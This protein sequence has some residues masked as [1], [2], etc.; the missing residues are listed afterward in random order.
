MFS[1]PFSTAALIGAFA[2]GALCRWP[3]AEDLRRAVLVPAEPVQQT[4][5]E[6]PREAVE[7]AAESASPPP[8]CVCECICG[9][10]GVAPEAT[11]CTIGL[12]LWASAEVRLTLAGLATAAVSFLIGCC[13][14]RPVP[15]ERRPSAL[16]RLEGYRS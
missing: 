1:G 16:S 7:T 13:C 11:P 6:E 9:L 14:R 4:A 12:A 10:A 5:R 15:R 2:A 8:P 3:G